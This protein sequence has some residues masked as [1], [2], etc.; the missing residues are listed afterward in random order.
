MSE[1][2]KSRSLREEPIRF[3]RDKGEDLSISELI[4]ER[5]SEELRNVNI[6]PELFT[7]EAFL[8]MWQT[9]SRLF[10]EHEQLLTADGMEAVLDIK[11]AMLTPAQ[12]L[13]YLDALEDRKPLSEVIGS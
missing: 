13:G 7:E 5:R 4:G 9:L 1:V 3:V 2:P 6:D 10:E 11:S 8:L 12:M